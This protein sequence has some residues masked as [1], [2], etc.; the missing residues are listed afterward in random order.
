MSP[1]ADDAPVL[2]GVGGITQRE[3]DPER[4][5]EP[6]ELLARAF[7]QAAEDAGS[8]ALLEG[9]DAVMMPRGLW[10]YAD[11]TG[12]LAERLGAGAKRPR[13]LVAEIGVLQTTLLSRAARAIQT[14][15]A[16]VVLVGGTEAKYRAVSAERR[17]R[18]APTLETPGTPDE[19]LRPDGPILSRREIELGLAR[20]VTGYA[21]L[22]NALRAFE[23]QALDAHRDDVAREWAAQ[24]EA[25]VANPDAW[26]R[27]RVAASDL[28]DASARNP[29]LAFPYTR[30]HCSSWNVDQ[31]AALI[32]CSAGKARRLGV[33]PERF[34]HPLAIADSD[35]MRVVPERRFLHRSPGFEAVFEA[36]LSH[37]GLGTEEIAH[38]ELYS[39][40]PI[41]MRMQRRALG[42]DASRP[43]TLTGGMAFAGG[44]LNSFA[45]QSL[46]TLARALRADPG[47][48]GLLTAVSG[49]VN[50]QGASVWS[51]EPAVPFAAFDCTRATAAAEGE[52][53][54]FGAPT[55]GPA[56]VASYTVLYD[57]DTPAR[58]ALLCDRPDG[59]RSL[60][61]SND[62]ELADRA[63][64]EELCGV[65]F[66]RVPD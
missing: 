55:P 61:V 27:E 49:I 9:A 65:D 64:R 60:S 15:A 45:L 23:K 22:E 24:S 3:E 54:P 41:A 4:A 56:R 5:H 42:L 36:V 19:V 40:F 43:S 6:V 31:A 16:E 48:R 53:I 38:L 62:R 28:R 59:S 18:T 1:A 11:P 2:V 7:E 52:P 37:T 32:L 33:P 25:A 63:T 29:M 66:A 17:G 20:P 47:S 30:A 58:T 21:L 50:K 14:G 26:R 13:T 46:V 35:E 44:P 57:G 8:R 39:C 12:W 34:V 10:D 51:T